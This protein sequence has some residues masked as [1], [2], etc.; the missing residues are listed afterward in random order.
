MLD[1]SAIRQM[2]YSIEAEQAILGTLIT[3]PEKFDEIPFLKTDDF[4]LE[5]WYSMRYLVF[6]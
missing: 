3:D 5:Q 1:N 2:P 4:Y 6:Q